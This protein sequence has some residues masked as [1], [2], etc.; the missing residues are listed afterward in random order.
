MES[1]KT[2]KGVTRGS[3]SNWVYSTLPISLATGSIGTVVQLYII[4]L[5]GTSLGTIY[6]TLA[7]AFF[8]GVTIPASIFWGFVTDRLHQRMAVIFS[9]YLVMATVFFSFNN[10]DTVGIIAEYSVLAFV[11][12]A[13]ATPL[14]LLVMETEPKSRWADGFAKLSMAS[15]IGI[16]AGLVLSTVWVQFFPLILISLPFSVLSLLSA[17]LALV[18]IHE[19]PIVLEQETIVM[20]RPS[21]LNR[22]VAL[23]LMF[24]SIPKVS[25][26]R[27]IFRGLRYG[28]TSYVPLLYISTVLFWLSAGIFNS[29]VVPAMSAF[30][31]SHSEIFGALLVGMIIQTIAFRYAGSYIGNKSLESVASAGLLARGASYIAIGLFAFVLAQPLFLFPMLIFYP[32]GAGVAF[33]IYYTASNTMVFNS[34]KKGSAGSALGVYSAVVGMSTL[35]GS[36]VSGFISVYVGFHTTFVTAGLLLVLA[37]FVVLKLKNVEGVG[38][39]D[40]D[41]P[42]RK[43]EP[44]SEDAARETG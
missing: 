20:R 37:A 44:S 28:M 33:A 13:S 31:L 21:F 23:P 9:S 16:T 12:A 1:A 29:S 18:L 26:F 7:F 38:G 27:R 8:Y 36:L 17:G 19:P 10:L 42:V 15:G 34:V 6:A 11:S 2:A 14:S 43:T 24:L 39:A 5:N 30:S 3:K 4:Q 35:A 25:D 22:L 32:I 41:T 40:S